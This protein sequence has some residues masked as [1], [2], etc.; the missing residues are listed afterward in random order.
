MATQTEVEQMLPGMQKKL[1]I[2]SLVN[3]DT[4]KDLLIG[5]V[6]KEKLDP[7]NIDIVEVVD[8]YIAVVKEL[9][10]M[11]LRVPAN[12]ILAASILLRLKSELLPIRYEEPLVDEGMVV[13]GR[14]PPLVE[15]LSLRLRPPIKRK[16]SLTELIEALDEAMKIK[17]TR[18]TRQTEKPFEFPVTFNKINIEEDMNTLY[19][20]IKRHADKEKMTTFSYLLGAT[21]KEDVLLQLF[22]P[23]LFLANKGKISLIQEKFFE[24]IIIRLS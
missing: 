4:W 18:A 1:D 7:W 22:I 8:S 5:L 19:D 2:V 10:T 6:E 15:E 11:D 17:E 23:L 14:I 12:I 13:E 3:Y 16:L 20:E 21:E 9:K 24:D